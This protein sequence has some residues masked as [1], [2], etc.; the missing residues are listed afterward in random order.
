ML[1]TTADGLPEF[2]SHGDHCC[3]WYPF[4]AVSV[5]W[6]G[7]LQLSVPCTKYSSSF[8]LGR[9]PFK[10]KLISFPYTMFHL[11]NEPS[12]PCLHLNHFLGPLCMLGNEIS[13][14][15]LLCIWQETVKKPWPVL[16]FQHSQ[17]IS[18]TRARVREAEL[19]TWT[20][21]RSQET[22]SGLPPWDLAHNPWQSDQHN[23]F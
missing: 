13:Q 11:K 2:M 6:R 16:W 14:H 1:N 15:R 17:L 21:P 20:I 8:Q 10:G 23:S 18:S 5:E 4:Q 19:M 22:A 7:W 3:Y 9:T 12:C